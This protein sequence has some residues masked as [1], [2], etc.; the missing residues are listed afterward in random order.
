[1]RFR[2]YKIVWVVLFIAFFSAACQTHSRLHSNGSRISGIKPQ[3][4]AVMPFIKGLPDSRLNK[5]IKPPLYCPIANLCFNVSDIQNNADERMTEYLQDA[6]QQRYPGALIPLPA[7]RQTYTALPKDAATDTPLSLAVALGR[8]LG[9]DHV[10]VGIVWR[11]QERVGSGKA[12]SRPASVA[13]SVYLLSA[14]TNESVW[15]ATF[16]KT[17]QPL[18][19]NLLNIRSFFRMGARW[20]TADELARYGINKVLDAAP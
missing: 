16:D 11:Y 19:E 18:S 14:Q 12:A 15:E 20:L 4:I 2:V 5:P 9:A 3:R 7:V 6:L 10:M 13:F 17:Q 1:M 8:K